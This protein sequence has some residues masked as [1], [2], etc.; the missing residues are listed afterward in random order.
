M[1]YTYYLSTY[2]LGLMNDKLRSS[3]PTASL[4]YTVMDLSITFTSDTS[5]MSTIAGVK[6]MGILPGT[7]VLS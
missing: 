5:N 3:H 2:V 6:V 1:I 4:R 7:L